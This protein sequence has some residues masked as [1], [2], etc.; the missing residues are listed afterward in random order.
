MIKIDYF[1]GMHG[2]FL[3][4]VVNVFI[5]KCLPSST[6]IL[7]TELG[8]AHNASNDYHK[9]KIVYSG[10]YSVWNQLTFDSTDRIIRISADYNNDDLFFIILTNA[11]IRTDDRGFDG[12]IANIRPDIVSDSVKHRNFWYDRLLNRHF[13]SDLDFFYNPT[14]F[15]SC[16][17]DIFEF[18]YESFQS[19]PSF[20]KEIN[21]LAFWLNQTFYPCDELCSLWQRWVDGNQGLISFNKC[22]RILENIFLNRSCDIDCTVL[23]EAWINVNISKICRV[24]EGKIFNNTEYPSNTQEIRED[25]KINKYLDAN[26]H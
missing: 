7:A 25:L 1:A 11:I 18:T 22:S 19:L 13:Y 17:N 8:T 6:D 9:N 14:L 26:A 4:Y 21:R 3:E 5:M 23:E 24:Y 20:L 15:R 2:K 16:P 10:T 12:Y